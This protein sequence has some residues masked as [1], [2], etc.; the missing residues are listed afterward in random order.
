MLMVLDVGHSSADDIVSRSVI[1]RNTLKEEHARI[2]GVVLNQV[3][4]LQPADIQ[5]MLMSSRGCI[6][7]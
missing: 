2:L 7:L 6:N 1:C 3:L 5:T 4:P